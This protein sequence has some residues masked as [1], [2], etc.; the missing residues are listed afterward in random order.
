VDLNPKTKNINTLYE[1]VLLVTREWKA[2]LLS[3]TMRNLSEIE[4]INPNWLM[5]DGYLS[6]D[7]I[8]SMITVID[9]NKIHTL[10]SNKIIE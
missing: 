4:D 1:I 9:N 7:W 10:D 5:L 8:E 6:A 2:D 3:K